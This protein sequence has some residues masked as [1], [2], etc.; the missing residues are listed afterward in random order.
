MAIEFLRKRI[1][2]RIGEIRQQRKPFE[3]EDI[4]DLATVRTYTIFKL[5]DTFREQI[6][7]EDDP[8]DQGQGNA[9]EAF[10]RLIERHGRVK[11]FNS[12][13]EVVNSDLETNKDL[14]NQYKAV[15]NNILN[16]I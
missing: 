7:R 5:R 4:R 11:I 15:V 14:F 2:Q 3:Q 9:S 13:L 10:G 16:E 1:G 12:L 8:Q 6:G